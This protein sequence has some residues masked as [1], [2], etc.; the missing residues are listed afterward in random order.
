MDFLGP[1]YNYADEIF[2]P[3][4]IGVKRGDSFGSVTNAIDG[5]AYYLDTI[6][7]GQSSNRMTAGKP[8]KHYGINYFIKTGAKCSNGADMNQYIETI[9]KGDAFGKNIGKAIAE[10]GATELRGLA[11]GIVEDAKAA[12]N[13]APLLGALM[14]SGYPRCKLETRPVGD[15]YGYVKSTETG[16]YWIED[17]STLMT[18]TPDLNTGKWTTNNQ[19]WTEL[20]PKAPPPLG[21]LYRPCQTRWV[22]DKMVSKEEWDADEKIYNPDGTPASQT[23][24]GFDDTGPNRVLVAILGTLIVANLWALSRR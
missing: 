1:N 2:R 17:P 12:M 19:K 3:A 6:A 16:D 18:C 22:L 13:P 23:T 14:G 15:E 21:S 8:F 9:P 4:A 11:P 5:M 10:M 24:E 20:N 7:F